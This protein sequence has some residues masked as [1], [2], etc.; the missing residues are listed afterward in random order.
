MFEIPFS[1]LE[2]RKVNMFVKKLLSIGFVALLFICMVMVVA[3]AVS[4]TKLCVDIP[5]WVG[6]YDHE[7]VAN[8]NITDVEDLY[9]FEFKL[10]W[11]TT[12]LDI[13][14]VNITSPEEWGTNYVIFKNET[15]ENY[16]ATH[17]RYWLNMSALTP[18][19]SFNGSTVLAKLTFKVTYQPFYPE[20]GVWVCLNLYDTKLNNPEGL[21]I[22]HEAYDDLYFIP[23]ELAAIP[24]LK[25]MPSYYQAT[26]LGEIFTIDVNIGPLC[27]HLEFAGWKAKLGYNTTL[28]DVLKVEEGPFLQQ[29]RTADKRYFTADIHEGEGYI[30]MTGGILGTCATPFGLGTLAKITFNATY[31]TTPPTIATCVLDLYDTNH[32]DSYGQPLGLP[33]IVCD[34]SYQAPHAELTGDLNEDGVVDIVDIVICALA[35]G[36]AAEDNPETPWNETRNWNPIA[37]LNSDAIIDIVDLVII[38]IHFGETL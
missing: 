9:S 8:V 37:D 13:V 7:F 32:T 21:P 24:Y 31:I 6:W 10:S 20:P 22:P 3:N 25:V 38:A 36:S 4:V 28:L 11:N 29:F 30:N 12:C 14:G 23:T 5:C 19:P 35:F 2:R 16:N 17:G 1:L 33:P 27:A 26:T 18:A 34:G 15:I